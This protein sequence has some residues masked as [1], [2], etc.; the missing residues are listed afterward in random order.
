MN[1][2]NPSLLVAYESAITRESKKIADKWSSV[3]KFGYTN[4]MKPNVL[5]NAVKGYFITILCDF[6]DNAYNEALKTAKSYL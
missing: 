5:K 4:E 2:T 6:D 3:T 1:N